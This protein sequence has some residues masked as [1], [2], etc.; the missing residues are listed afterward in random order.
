MTEY[1]IT[2]PEKTHAVTSRHVRVDI[3]QTVSNYYLQEITTTKY[4]HHIKYN[5]YIH[6]KT[7]TALEN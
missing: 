1:K 5:F 2:L 7:S 3:V 4:H 6:T